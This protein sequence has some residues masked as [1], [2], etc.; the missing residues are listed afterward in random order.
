MNQ[1]KENA[2]DNQAA[3][4]DM[5]VVIAINGLKKSFGGNE[6]LK[7]ISLELKKGENVVVLGRSG[8]GKSVTIECIVGLLKPDGGSV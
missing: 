7:D 5:E 2:E 6:V 3:K 4:T 1:E 8:T